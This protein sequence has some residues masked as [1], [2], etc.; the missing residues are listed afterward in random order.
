MRK[1]SGLSSNSFSR[2]GRSRSIRGRRGFSRSRSRRRGGSCSFAIALAAVRS[3]SVGVASR[4][5]GC[6]G[7]SA[8]SC[9]GGKAAD[10]LR[11]DCSCGSILL[12]TSSCVCLSIS[13]AL[14]RGSGTGSLSRLGSVL[15][16]G[17]RSRGRNT[18][19]RRGWSVT[20]LHSSSRALVA[21]AR[22]GASRQSREVFATGQPRCRGRRRSTVVLVSRASTGATGTEAPVSTAGAVAVRALVV[23]V[24]IVVTLG[25]TTMRH[26]T[27]AVLVVVPINA[28]KPRD[29]LH[30]SSETTAVCGC[31]S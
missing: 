14:N 16:S 22:R 26:V 28:W 12:Y 15:L 18:L 19:L 6:W 31:L 1:E 21:R 17:L 3:A 2:G 7:R 13:L 4:L 10:E 24:A 27:M 29:L 8:A 11:D 25:S 9:G 23:L 5:S 30:R 20:L